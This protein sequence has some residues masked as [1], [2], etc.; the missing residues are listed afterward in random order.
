MNITD[1]KLIDILVVDDN[2]GDALLIREALKSGKIFN[3]LIIVKD[4]LEAMDLLRRKGNYAD[5]PR[6]DLIFLDLDLP[7][8]NGRQV[9][10]EIKSDDELKQIPVVIVTTSQSEEDIV[11]TYNLQANCYVTKPIDLVQFI[12]VVESI[13]D[14]GLSLVKRPPQN[15]TGLF[16]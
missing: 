12:K 1:F 3:S 8:M 2:P 10:A 4:G 13:E 14:F 11:K 15:Q 7:K 6:P 5:A 9:L 16:L